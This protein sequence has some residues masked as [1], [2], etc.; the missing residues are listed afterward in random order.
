MDF[1]LIIVGF[2]PV[3]AVAANLAG[4]A[5]LRTLVLEKSLTIYDKPRAM[6]FDQEV[7]RIFGNLGIGEQIAPYVMPYRPS[8]YR[9]T[10][11]RVIRRIG[12]AEP[13]FQLGWA[14]NYVFMQ[15]Q[16]EG[17]L[18]E[19]LARFPSVTVEL[20]AEV[21]AVQS[22]QDGASVTVGL[23][24]GEQQTYRSDYVLACDGGTSPI[25]TGLGLGMEDLDFDEPWLV[26][27]VVL[28]DGCGDNL[29]TT[30]VQYCEIARPCTF[31]V[32]PGRV[33]RWEFMINPG[34]TPA[35]VMEPAFVRKL[36]SR[37]LGDDEYDI[38]RASSYRF[39]ALVLERWRADRVFFLGDAAHMTPPFL[40]QGMCQ[41]IRDAAN[42]VWKLTLVKRGAAAPALL[43]TY[44]AE[45]LPHVKQT[46]LVTK[47]LGKLICERDPVAAR[48]R[49][50]RLLEEVAAN[51]R[52]TV[53]QS[54]IPGLNAGFLLASPY[55]PRGQL[56]PQPR[57]RQTDESEGLLDEV[58]GATFRVV[59]A[60]DADATVVA[61]VARECDALR[62]AGVRLVV[63]GAE[64]LTADASPHAY[65]DVSGVLLAWMRRHDCCAVIVR[66][67]HYVY[68][69]CRRPE[70]A[71]KLV[72]ELAAALSSG[73]PQESQTL[74]T[75]I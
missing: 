66:P 43:D 57:V 40:A 32:G 20:G 39:H 59:I 19:N 12:A 38:W 11:S 44:Q 64:Q 61:Q 51:P 4:Q 5:G 21:T 68:G 9:T 72:Q 37:W 18:R 58:T 24:S 28:R 47:G 14:P 41:G 25:R 33:R 6:G 73:T 74:A 55:G 1:D 65:Q 54:L 70:D 17:T 48:E 16:I 13:P 30:N 63:I 22:G 45:R 35:E 29:P 10:D 3:G 62:D 50:E 60:A 53:R 46:T 31:V 8:E 2:G 75:C 26:V 49:D 23:A 27:D 34:E 15:P 52:G 71:A 42:L 36:I 67:D 69:A 7:M 56:F